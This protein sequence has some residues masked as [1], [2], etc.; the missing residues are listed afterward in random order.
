MRPLILPIVAMVTVV[1][2]SN[3]LVQFAIN[4]FLTWAAF[5][6][7][8]AFLVTDLTNRHFGPAKARR[9][10]YFGF[11]IGIVLSIAFAGARIG[12]ASGIAFL[13]GQ[14]LDVLIFDRMRRMSWWRAPLVSS[15]SASALDTA[16]FFSIAFVGTGVPWITLGLGD[17]AVK[18]GM[19]A[20]LL[21]PYGALMRLIT[22]LPVANADTRLN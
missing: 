12:M 22:P 5:T 4:D 9:V 16:L 13:A 20:T 1:V 3:I 19:A 7:P 10:I 6:F 2:A 11:A 8:I 15:V 21:V 18:L 14:L 17:F